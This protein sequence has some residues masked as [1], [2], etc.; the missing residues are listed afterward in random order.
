MKGSEEHS[1]QTVG[2][3]SMHANKQKKNTDISFAQ[4]NLIIKFHFRYFLYFCCSIVEFAFFSTKKVNLKR[5][6]KSNQEKSNL[7]VNKF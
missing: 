1:Q 2:K 7:S 3:E 5:N 4:G 6:Q